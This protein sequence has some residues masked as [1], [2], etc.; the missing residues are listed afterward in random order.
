MSR[1]SEIA[2]L[3]HE[4]ENLYASAAAMQRGAMYLRA[5]IGVV[6]VGAVIAAAYSLAIM[7]IPGSALGILI[8]SMAG[9]IL[10]GFKMNWIGMT[11]WGTELVRADY[12]AT[13]QIMIRD[14]ESRLAELK[15]RQP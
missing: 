11:G 12:V 5:F 3:E 6:A 7:S 4:L 10:I 9:A 14:R 1:A 2:Q 13:T 8:A 15:G